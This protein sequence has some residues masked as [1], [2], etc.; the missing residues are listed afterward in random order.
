[1]TFSSIRLLLI[2][3]CLLSA[4]CYGARNFLSSQPQKN[5]TP[6]HKNA[7]SKEGNFL[8]A[9]MTLYRDNNS[10]VRKSY[11]STD[12][13]DGNDQD[14][15]LDNL[16][17]EF[18]GFLTNT[19]PISQTGPTK[20]EQPAQLSVALQGQNPPLLPKKSSLSSKKQKP[21]TQEGNPPALPPKAQKLN[22][23]PE[24]AVTSQE[25]RR[26]PIPLKQRQNNVQS[27]QT[28]ARKGILKQT[29]HAETTKKKVRWW[30]QKQDQKPPLSR[31]QPSNTRPEHSKTTNWG[32]TLSPIL[33]APKIAQEQA[34]QGMEQFYQ[35]IPKDNTISISHPYNTHNTMKTNPFNLAPIKPAPNK[36][37]PSVLKALHNRKNWGDAGSSVI[38]PPIISWRKK[39]NLS[40]DETLTK[41]R[42]ALRNCYLAQ[43]GQKDP[44]VSIKGL[45]AEDPHDFIR[46]MFDQELLGLEILLKPTQPG[47]EQVMCPQCFSKKK[48]EHILEA[49]K[50]EAEKAQKKLDSTN[51]EKQ[52]TENWFHK[53]FARL[54]NAL[55]FSRKTDNSQG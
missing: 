5:Q 52:E 43:K 14:L 12:I 28:R 27:Q 13:H 23:A 11:S 48:C 33:E 30:D 20:N 40:K 2:G 46:N 41:I 37:S 31:S 6:L 21:A 25:S 34:I 49:Q 22:N 44:V 45:E 50:E 39:N 29:P 8:K 7:P 42:E 4:S 47:V 3:T 38:S 24:E 9:S 32:S 1:M 36:H 53:L 10:C 17:K 19:P 26:P 35:Q 55:K 18:E 51:I 54:K 16:L 15:A